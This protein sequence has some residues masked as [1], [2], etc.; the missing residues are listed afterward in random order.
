MYPVR[1]RRPTST[2]PHSLVRAFDS[3]IWT[4]RTTQSIRNCFRNS[5]TPSPLSPSSSPKDRIPGSS[6]RPSEVRLSIVTSL[7]ATGPY[8]RELHQRL[9]ASALHIAEDYEII[10]VNDASPD[11]ALTIAIQLFKADGHVR[12]IDLSRNF[13][14]HRAL[15]V[16]LQH[17]RGDLVFLLDSDLEEDPELLE[18]FYEI[19]LETRADVV[20]GTQQSRKGGTFERWSGDI[21]YTLFNLL[22][23]TT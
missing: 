10:L 14:Q 2:K 13:G 5:T 8:L 20:Y 18:R 17:A 23:S 6:S 9:T 3:R 4:T 15:M 19:L 1:R 21:F 12:V 16:G 7:Y 11:D 22:A